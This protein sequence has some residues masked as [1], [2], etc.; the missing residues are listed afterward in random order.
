MRANEIESYGITCADW[1]N[2]VLG[3]IRCSLLL[4]LASDGH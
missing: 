3:S 4:P 1:A 2:S